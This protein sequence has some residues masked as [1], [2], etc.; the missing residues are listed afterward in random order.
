MT[1]EETTMTGF[2]I[3]SYSGDARSKL[4]TA[5]SKAKEKKFVMLQKK[6]RI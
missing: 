3:V 6:W 4:L 2:E 5:L 1:K